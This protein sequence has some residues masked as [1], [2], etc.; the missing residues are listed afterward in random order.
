MMYCNFF[1]EAMYTANLSE[2]MKC[3]ILN[4]MCKKLR[5]Q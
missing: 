4:S 1:S 5:S 3:K 2:S